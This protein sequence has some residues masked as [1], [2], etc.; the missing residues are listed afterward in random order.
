LTWCGIRLRIKATRIVLGVVGRHAQQRH[1]FGQRHL[2]RRRY[3]SAA[4]VA[5]RSWRIPIWAAP[6]RC[7]GSWSRRG[8]DCCRRLAHQHR[9]RSRQATRRRGPPSCT[10]QS[11]PRGHVLAVRFAASPKCYH[12]VASRGSVHPATAITD[13]APNRQAGIRQR[14]ALD[15]QAADPARQGWRMRPA[16]GGHRRNGW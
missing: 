13:S 16:A 7:F 2:H 15:D 6:P 9:H 1:R 4:S 5:P 11:G 3:E 14:R 10:G 12:R 8:T